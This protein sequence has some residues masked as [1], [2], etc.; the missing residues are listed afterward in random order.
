MIIPNRTDRNQITK[1]IKNV[2]EQNSGKAVVF[3]IITKD[4]VKIDGL[5]FKEMSD[6]LLFRGI[7]GISLAIDPDEI[8]EIRYY[9]YGNRTPHMK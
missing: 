1:I 2:L 5:I 3:N 7:N 8:K 4:R 6:K 9:A